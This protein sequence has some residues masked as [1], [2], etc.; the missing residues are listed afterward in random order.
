MPIKGMTERYTPT[1]EGVD[2][3]SEESIGCAIRQLE[4]HLKLVKGLLKE[5][6]Q[7]MVELLD[8]RHLENMDW[9]DGH[10]SN[11]GDRD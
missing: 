10:P 9:H 1:L 11:F 5:A 8:S 2:W 3:G 7:N 4:S 6:N